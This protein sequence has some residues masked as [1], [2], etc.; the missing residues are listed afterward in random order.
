MAEDIYFSRQKNSGEK[1][2]QTASY[3]EKID[4]DSLKRRPGEM[5]FGDIVTENGKINAGVSKTPREQKKAVK[6]EKKKKKK[7][8]ILRRILSAV[9]AVIIALTLFITAGSA[10]VLSDYKAQ[11]MKNNVHTEEASLLHSSSV[12]NVLLMGIDTLDTGDASR[13]DAMILLSLDMKNGQIKLSSFLRDSYVNIPG[14][15]NMKLNA[16]CVYGGPRLV[17]D[18]IEANFGIRIDDYAK[19]GY[20]MFIKIIDAVGGI[21]IPEIDETEAKALKREGFE[22]EPGTNIHVDGKEALQY[23]RIRRG[24]DDFYRTGRQREVISLVLKKLPLSNPVTL[25][26]TAKE[27][28]GTIECSVEKSRFPSLL[29]KALMCITGD[30]EQMT[31]PADGT[32][33]NDT[34][35]YQAVLVVDFDA[36][37]EKLNEFLYK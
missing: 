3:T 20:D 27:I 14:Y 21:T 35:N 13:S 18:T 31:V 4:S 28:A 23:C 22:T 25:L 19:V 33:Y 26:K 6:K 7:L 30:I 9:L 17:C 32:W 34:K 15:G 24:Q 10:Y 12:Y 11:E 36:N 29:M 1:Q 16:A 2:K 8:R 37:R 5:S